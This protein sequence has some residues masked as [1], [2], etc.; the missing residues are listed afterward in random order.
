MV[1]KAGGILL[2]HGPCPLE[3]CN[4]SDGCAVYSKE[5]EEENN[6][7]DGYCFSCGRYVNRSYFTNTPAMQKKG[8]MVNDSIDNINSLPTRELTDRGLYL[9]T[10]E[11]FGVR[12]GLSLENGVDIIEHFYPKTQNGAVVGYKVRK[13]ATKE[14]YSLGVSK[15]LDLFGYQQAQ[16]SGGKTIFI[17]EGECDAMAVYQALKE[18]AKG[19]KWENL[20]PAVVSVNNGASGAKRELV[21][22]LPF[23]ER[24]ENIVLVFD[25]DEPG[26]KAAFDS[27]SILPMNKVKVAALSGKDPNQMLQDGKGRE[28]RD[29]V[30]FRAV[31]FR[32]DGMKT[33]A[34]LKDAMMK[35]VEV[36]ERWPWASVTKSTY[37][38]RSG[39][40]HIFGAGSGCGKTEAFKEM[41]HTDY[42]LGNKVGIFFLEEAAGRTA[43]AIA[44]KMANR[45]FH[46]PDSGWDYSEL[47]HWYNVLAQKNLLFIYDDN[48]AGPRSWDAIKS[49]IKY[50]V[51]AEGIK[52][53]YLDHLTALT[54][55]EPDE[56]RAL[57]KMLAEMAAMV[58]DLDFTLYAISHLT[59]PG[60]GR[61]SHEEGGRVRQADFRGSGSIQFWAHYMWAIERNT[62]ADDP[63]ERNKVMFRCLKDRLSGN[64]TGQ[65]VP[66][67]FNPETGRLLEQHHE[68]IFLG[69]AGIE[70]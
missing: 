3:G 16:A 68:G 46:I 17:T 2:G 38:R 29:S 33:I 60:Q 40:V 65:I 19:T 7:T 69:E 31:S 25:S 61:R 57:D 24:F 62:Q 9:K 35:K 14:F 49:R 6:Y 70:L 18:Q 4:S 23:L 15:E 66:M 27:A 47:E 21:Q 50:L 51:V 44:G 45:R 20:E 39:E 1:H 54:A 12:V 30:M 43:K 41:I 37:G 58:E 42:E 26:K 63:V 56:R 34:D 28:L 59:R 52:H 8:D 32:P 10:C 11:H 48:S 55:V 64:A 13:V 22:N 5:D 36:G 53:I 67:V